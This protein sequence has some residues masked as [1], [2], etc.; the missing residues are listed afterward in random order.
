MFPP[1]GLFLISKPWDVLHSL[2]LNIQD[3]IQRTSYMYIEFLSSGHL[4]M[5]VVV[6]S[7]LIRDV[8]L[9]CLIGNPKSRN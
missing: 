7:C 6:Y 2:D 5:K 3:M 8:C 9:L 1:S 4:D